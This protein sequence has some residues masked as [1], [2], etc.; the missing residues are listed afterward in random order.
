MI[1]VNNVKF[2]LEFTEEEFTALEKAARDRGVYTFQLVRQTL[3]LIS[4]DAQKE[5]DNVEGV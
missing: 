3:E 4:E 1:N 5:M 2:E